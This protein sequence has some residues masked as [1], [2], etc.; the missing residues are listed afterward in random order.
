MSS[1]KG[2]RGPLI[3]TGVTT[4]NVDGV[5]GRNGILRAGNGGEVPRSTCIGVKTKLLVLGRIRRYRKA[6]QGAPQHRS[7]SRQVAS[8]RKRSGNIRFSLVS[9]IRSPTSSDGNSASPQSIRFPTLSILTRQCKK[10]TFL[11]RRY[12]HPCNNSFAHTHFM[13]VIRDVRLHLQIFHSKTAQLRSFTISP[14][15]PSFLPPIPG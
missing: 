10:A 5:S 8:V 1:I 4:S 12:N 11:G 13:Q 9:P 15:Y 2:S 6:F 3:P 14:R 7:R